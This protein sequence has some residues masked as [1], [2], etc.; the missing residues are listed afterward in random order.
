M[1][2]LPEPCGG[3]ERSRQHRVR[4]TQARVLPDGFEHDIDALAVE[5][6]RRA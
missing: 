6:T 2:V 5:S 1:R 3:R 4:I